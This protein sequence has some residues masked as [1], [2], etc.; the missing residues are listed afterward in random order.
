[1]TVVKRTGC[2]LPNPY[3]CSAR[4]MGMCPS[5]CPRKLAPVEYHSVEDKNLGSI[6]PGVTA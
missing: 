2:V 6:T 5:I 4:L 3:I 1:M